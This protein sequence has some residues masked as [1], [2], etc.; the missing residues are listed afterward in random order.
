MEQRV[1]RSA[2][3]SRP[4]K[5]SLHSSKVHWPAQIDLR[6]NP[7][8][9]SSHGRDQS[10]SLV[11]RPRFLTNL[12]RFLLATLPTRFTART[13]SVGYSF[14]LPIGLRRDGLPIGPDERVH[15]P[16]VQELHPE[17]GPHLAAKRTDDICDADPLDNGPK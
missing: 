14:D 17:P 1:E 15:L 3:F 2:R 7:S 9:T 8:S 13:L 16:E 6:N 11:F 10:F 5:V 4:P 12:L